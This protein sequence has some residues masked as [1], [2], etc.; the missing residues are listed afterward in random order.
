MDGRA[1]LQQSVC[2][3][4]QENRPVRLCPGEETSPARRT[5]SNRDKS[6]GTD[7]RKPGTSFWYPP[8]RRVRWPDDLEPRVLQRGGMTGHMGSRG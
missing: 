6:G 5:S 7:H 3:V 2:P 4:D 8:T 1:E